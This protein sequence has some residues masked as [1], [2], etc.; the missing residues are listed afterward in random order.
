MFS[1]GIIVVNIFPER[2]SCLRG[3]CTRDRSVPQQK[4]RTEPDAVFHVNLD[5]GVQSDY[6]KLRLPINVYDT[7]RLEST[8]H[9]E[10]LSEET[11]DQPNE[12]HLT[13]V[14]DNSYDYIDKDDTH[15]TAKTWL[16]LV[17]TFSTI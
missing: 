12:P 1:N 15:N 17:R 6:E 8:E 9:V 4:L 7:I 11:K 14:D 16:P 3:I 5:P 13:S 2:F 10:S